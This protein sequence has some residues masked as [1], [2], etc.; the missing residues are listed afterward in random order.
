KP[1]AS[2]RRTYYNV[3]SGD[4]VTMVAIATS[5]SR[6]LIGHEPGICYIG[7][8][9]CQ[10]GCES[11]EWQL[12][13]GS[14]NGFN[15]RFAFPDPTSVN[16]K[17]VS[18]ILIVPTIPTT[19]DMHLLSQTASDLR[20]EPF[21]A[22][23][24]QLSSGDMHDVESWRKVTSNFVSQLTPL[25]KRFVNPRDVSDVHPTYPANYSFAQN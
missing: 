6:D 15:Y 2:F 17:V 5:H 22:V 25:V 14:V 9:W 7:Q 8:G 11:Y 19:G 10:L 4:V 18:S 13:D 3:K 23:A 1:I 20:L 12:N 21:G 16:Q 24:I